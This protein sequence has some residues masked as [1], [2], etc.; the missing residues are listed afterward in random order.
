M[1]GV[2]TNCSIIDAKDHPPGHPAQKKRIVSSQIRA[3]E[4]EILVI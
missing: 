3:F 1:D 4:D 2:T